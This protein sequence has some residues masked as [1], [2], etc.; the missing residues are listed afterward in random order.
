MLTLRR[1]I[2]FNTNVELI[3]KDKE[4]GKF[5]VSTRSATAETNEASFDSVFLCT[6]QHRKPVIPEFEQGNDFTGLAFHYHDMKDPKQLHGKRVLVVGSS[7][8]ALNLHNILA[9]KASSF[10][11][12]WRDH[13]P[14]WCNDSPVNCEGV[15]VK[16]GILKAAGNTVWFRDGTSAEIDAIVYA[17]GFEQVHP[18]S[19]ELQVDF[20]GIP[21]FLPL[22]KHAVHPG[23]PK[24]FF[25]GK[26]IGHI[27]P[28]SR[29]HAE[30][31]CAILNGTV[32]LPNKQEMEAEIEAFKEKWLPEL[33]KMDFINYCPLLDL[34]V[35][36]ADQISK[37]T[38]CKPI[39]PNTLKAYQALFRI[40]CSN[41]YTYRDKTLKPNWEEL[42]P[43]EE[44]FE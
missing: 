33:A 27:I 14:F 26:A 17:T 1:F 20:S 43:G 3:R 28:S 5:I 34:E 15:N 39:R 6:G 8:G 29:L 35:D 37:M 9:K 31:G 25:V 10:Y 30:M 21:C 2:K 24:I 11:L 16:Q 4:T 41:L 22:Y 40:M 18:L 23:E 13:K 42:G 19:D 7:F 36:L 44:L 12:V 38:G 32:E